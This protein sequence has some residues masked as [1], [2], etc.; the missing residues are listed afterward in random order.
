MNP[1]AVPLQKPHP[2]V[3]IPGVLS[4]ETI[5]WAAQQRYPYI[6]LSTAIEATKKIWELYDQVAAEH[7]LRR[8]PG[9][10]RLPAALPRRRDRGEGAGQRAAVH[11]DA[12]RV[13]RPRAPGVVEPVGLL[14]AVDT[15]RR[16]SSTP[17]AAAPTRAAPPSRTRSTNQQIVAGTPKTVIPKLRRLL[18]ETRP[19]IMGF[20]AS[21]GFVSHA[22]HAHLHPPAGR[23]GAAR[24]ARDR[25]GAGPLEP[26]RGERARRAARSPIPR[27]RRA[28]WRSRERAP[29]RPDRRREV[30]HRAV[31]A[32][33]RRSAP[34]PGARPLLR[35]RQ[36]RPPG[37]RRRR[38]LAA[39][40]R[41]HPRHR[42]PRAR[43]AR[44]ASSPCSRATISPPTGSATCR[45]TAT[46][47]RR[48]GS[49]AF[50]TPRPGP[51]ARA[52]APR[53]RSGGAWSSRRRA[54][55]PSTP[56]TL[57]AVDYEPLPAVAAT[58]AA[59]RPGA[60]AV[61]DEAPD[62]VAFVVGGRQARRGRPRRSRP[63]P[64]SRGSTSSSPAWRRRRSSR[65]RPSATTTGAPAATPSTPASRARTG[66]ARCSPSRSSRCRRATCAWS[67]A[68]SAAASAC[69][70]ASIRSWCSCCGRRSASAGR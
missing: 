17:W 47:K 20:W 59:T 45:P 15:A 42:R 48:D 57:V 34:H 43:E 31:R 35:R 25:Q 21:D 1:W 55:R 5:I 7:G 63:P 27:G 14:L 49:P 33:A 60:P 8:R 70:A 56:R 51:R 30:R 32:A 58:A 69:A 10:P 11:V 41:A 38:A 9:V 52:R 46:R 37:V 36:P 6:A 29:E 18:E 22:G 3:W 65:A 50:A 54:S 39:R 26:V 19:S 4:K 16:S 62:N 66:C 53:R 23:G 40:P 24:R 61:W 68:K 13:H 67:P 12:G 64:T 28:R 44:P 2:R